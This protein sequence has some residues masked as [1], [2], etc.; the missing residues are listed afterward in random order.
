MNEEL[1]YFIAPPL[2]GAFIGYITN[3]I[4]IRMLFKP[5]KEWR[6]LGIRV[7][8]T[9]G[10]IP[11]YRDELAKNIGEMVGNILLNKE[12][13]QN[14]LTSGHSHEIIDRV[15]Q[16]NIDD[17]LDYPCP[18]L[19]E[20]IPDGVKKTFESFYQ[21]V[22]NKLREWG[23]HYLSG[24]DFLDLAKMFI[25]SAFKQFSEKSLD[26]YISQSDIQAITEKGIPQL[27]EQI[28][29]SESFQFWIEDKVEE[30]RVNER[31]FEEY[32]PQDLLSFA[33]RWLDREI[34]DIL[35]RIEAGVFENE[36]DKKVFARFK[37]VIF[38]YLE[39]LNS[40]QKFFAN[41]WG[42]DDRVKEDL[43]KIIREAIVQI[44]LNLKLDKNKEKILSAVM[45]SIHR[46]MAREVGDFFTKMN[47]ENFEQLKSITSNKVQGI[48]VNKGFQ[49][50]L[51]DFIIEYYN[52]NKEKP[53]AEIIES[54]SFDT[55]KIEISIADGIIEYLKDEK[56]RNEIFEKI[57]G[58]MD[59]FVYKHK[60]GKLN[61]ILHLSSA[62]TQH[63]SSY[64][65]EE[66]LLLL[67]RDIGYVVEAVNVQNVVEEKINTLALENVENLVLK[68]ISRH[69]K[70]INI[71]GALL[72][73]VVG[74]LQLLFRR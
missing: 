54:L 44:F 62:E 66:F 57:E 15:I 40:F 52:S 29:H 69:L 5:Y 51:N 47:N 12:T 4:A 72:G 60:I 20:L 23:H 14:Q 32:I 28:H 31:T 56:R 24:D 61:N 48:F 6:V 55:E 49:E 59:H 10:V 67:K 46:L 70:W 71:F 13:L 30:L 36:L 7:P 58:Q 9:P 18:S 65:S 43:P 53:L 64:L 1:L 63:I 73:A 35:D 41:A 39:Q 33:E 37:D 21:I 11:K 2:M 27:M 3:S 16:K 74:S 50:K 25:N 22:K 26:Q 19:F 42:V 8:F 68:I 34:P 45:K 17:A 38:S